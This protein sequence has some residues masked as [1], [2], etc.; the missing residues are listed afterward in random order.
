VDSGSD[1]ILFVENGSAVG[2]RLADA[3]PFI[4]GGNDKDFVV[5]MEVIAKCDEAGSGDA[6]VVGD[7][8]FHAGLHQE[9]GIPSGESPRYRIILI[10]AM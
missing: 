2:N 9:I 8:N 6:I 7:Q 1:S 3:A 10:Q 4:V 5:L